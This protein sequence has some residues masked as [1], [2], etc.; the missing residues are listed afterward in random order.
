MKKL[1]LVLMAVLAFTFVGCQGWL[2]I[3]DPEPEPEPDPNDTIAE[4][5]IILDTTAA[6]LNSGETYQINAECEYPISYTSENEYVAS[7]SEDGL[8]TANFV[9]TTNIMLEAEGD[10]QTFEVTVAP[11]SELYPEPEIE[12]GESKDAIVERFGDPDDEDE[13]II[14]YYGF[15]ESSFMLMVAF[16]DEDLV[17]YYMVVMEYDY[18]EELDTFLSERYLYVTEQDGVKV[19]I[20]ALDVNDAT[21]IVGSQVVEDSFVMAVYMGNDEGGGGDEKVVTPRVSKVLKRLAK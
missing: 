2:D 12:I 4:A 21:L 6:T 18:V 17:Q 9:G 5:L 20:N 13:E 3:P 19:Y 1:S 7:V 16:D 8:V 11:V 15:A 14:V 10:S